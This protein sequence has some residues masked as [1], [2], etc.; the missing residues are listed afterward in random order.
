MSIS[1]PSSSGR[2]MDRRSFRAHHAPVPSERRAQESAG[3]TLQV[4]ATQRI[5]RATVTGFNLCEESGVAL[6]DSQKV[7]L[8]TAAMLEV[9]G[10]R[11]ELDCIRHVERLIE[12]LGGANCS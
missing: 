11:D 2:T 8:L 3:S 12:G 5:A 9:D 6:A 10:L 7:A 1:L 4:V